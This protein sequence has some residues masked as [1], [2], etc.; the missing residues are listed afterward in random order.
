MKV[1]LHHLA[2][3]AAAFSIV[4]QGA[5]FAEAGGTV[6]L[7]GTWA[8]D[9]ATEDGSRE[10]EWKFE[11]DGDAV[12][13]ASKDYNNGTTREFTDIKVDGHRLTLEMAFEFDGNRGLIKVDAEQSSPGTLKGKWGLLGADGTEYATGA[14]TAVKEVTV[15]YAGEWDVTSVV[16]DGREMKAKLILRGEG[17]DLEGKFLGRNGGSLAIDDIAVTDQAVRL[18]FAMQIQQQP[19]DIVVE[20]D[21]DP[22]GNS[23]RGKWTRKAGDGSDAA[24]GAWSA[25]RMEKPNVS[26]KWG[27]TATTSEG[28][29]AGALNLFFHRDAEQYT[30][31]VTIADGPG[32]DLASVSVDGKS[33]TFS[34][35]FSR[36]DVSGTVSVEA[37][38]QDEGSLVGTWELKSVD[39][40]EVESDAWKAV[41]KE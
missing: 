26:G 41:R 30:G 36:G 37:E 32:T 9:A 7:P 25:E 29:M 3:Y 15:A 16:G 1:R 28:E 22:T 35:P 21:L 40:A 6:D 12:K 27:Y 18:A 2:T 34:L 13:G 19:A 5:A 23:L 39:G 33:V 11:K 17:S 38:L 31:N 10:L 24:S 14:L 4:A 8:V 20:A